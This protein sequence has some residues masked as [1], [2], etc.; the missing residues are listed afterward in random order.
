MECVLVFRQSP[1]SQKM[2]MS[3]LAGRKQQHKIPE[4]AWQ[5]VSE[6]DISYLKQ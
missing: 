3:N 5:R 4:S 1:E 6:E 2:S